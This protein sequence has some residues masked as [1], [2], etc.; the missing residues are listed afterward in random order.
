LLAANSCVA[1]IRQGAAFYKQAK[2]SFLEVKATADEVVGIY[3]EVTGF[4]NNFSNFFKPKQKPAT[5]KPV[6]QKKKEKFVAYTEAQAASDIVKQLTEFW[7]LQDQLNEFLRAEEAKAKVYNPNMSNAEMMGSAMNRI[8]CQQQMAELEV[9]I[10]EIMVYETPGLSDLYTQTFAMR[11]A[12]QEQQEQARLKQEAQNRQDAWLH[13]EKERN[14]Q[15][16]IAWVVATFIFLL[17]LWLWLALV[18]RWR[19]T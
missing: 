13:K 17:Y 15:L 19:Q 10:R 12:I 8:L 18:S 14:L 5:P 2:E 9:T 3:K 6:A 4:W 16:K 1:A 7:S 11:G